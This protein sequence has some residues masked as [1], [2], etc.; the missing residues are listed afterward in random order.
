[1]PLRA[2]FNPSLYSAPISTAKLVFKAPLAPRAYTK[3]AHSTAASASLPLTW[4]EAWSELFP[5]PSPTSSTASPSACCPHPHAPSF[6]ADSNYWHLRRSP[7]LQGALTDKFHEIEQLY[8]GNVSYRA[9]MSQDNP[10]LLEGL[11]LRGQRPPFMIVDCSDSRVNEGAIFDADPGTMFTAGNIANMFEEGDVSSNAVLTYA[12]KTLNVKHVVIMGHYGCGGVAASMAP[13]PEGYAEHWLGHTTLPA[14]PSSPLSSPSSSASSSSVSSSSTASS[15]T[16]TGPSSSASS[17]SSSSTTSGSTP[18]APEETPADL[19]V[20]R[21][22]LPIRKIYE[23]S[24]RPEIREHRERVQ[25][26]ISS[27]P[28]S[29]GTSEWTRERVARVLMGAE[30]VENSGEN[31]RGEKGEIGEVKLHDG[32]F[33]ALVE[34]NVKANVWRL[35][36][37]RVIREHHEAY[38]KALSTSEP[39]HPVYVHGWVYDLETG[40]VSDLGVSAGPPGW[41]PPPGG[42]QGFPAMRGA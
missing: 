34:E 17:P 38:T 8:L 39:L 42:V 11:A 4:R 5:S 26:L 28:S 33:R 37:S 10:G 20:Q 23:T 14:L 2:L 9:R 30:K 13:L 3:R 31:G 6:N 18:S 1:M 12:V 25:R 7:Q 15:S 19:A 21:W 36:R 16:S 27:S 41:V 32:A 35:G 22:I 24:G 29:P 40:V